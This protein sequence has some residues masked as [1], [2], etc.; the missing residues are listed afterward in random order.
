MPS[1]YILKSIRNRRYYVGSTINFQHRLEEHR[2]GKVRSTKGLCP[3]EVVFVQN[4]DSITKAKQI[5][6]RIKK[7]KRKDYIERIIKDKFI[8]MKI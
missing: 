6:Y 1:V 5:E 7:L 4:F 3:F 2:K 8:K